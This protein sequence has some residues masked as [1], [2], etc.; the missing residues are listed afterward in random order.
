VIIVRNVAPPSD[1]A[2]EEFDFSDL[3]NE[4]PALAPA[5]PPAPAPAGAPPAPA[6]AAP[7][8]N[9]LEVPDLIV[10]TS[11]RSVPQQAAVAPA[12]PQP[13]AAPPAPPSAPR[14]PAAPAAP[15]AP[16]VKQ[17]AAPAPPKRDVAVGDGQSTMGRMIDDDDAFAGPSMDLELDVAPNSRGSMPGAPASRPSHPS[18]PQMAAGGAPSRPSNP[19]MAAR[20]SHPSMDDLPADDDGSQEQAPKAKKVKPPKPKPKSRFELTPEE[21]AA[22]DL[23]EYG[24]P[25][26]QAWRAPLYA[27]RVLYRKY[28]LR[29]EM[30][31]MVSTRPEQIPLYQRALAVDDAPT[32]KKGVII[33]A[34]AIFIFLFLFTLPVIIRFAKL[35]MDG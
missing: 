24:D 21:R 8:G 16:A 5:R 2:G 6:K 35:A 22:V 29:K 4:D 25:P 27:W 15:I 1:K 31:E 3:F 18:N 33:A 34:A 12:P 7:P 19:Q 10:P 14:A 28:E 17:A 23:A 9:V 30:A 13:A 26:E 32:T 11:R 20:G